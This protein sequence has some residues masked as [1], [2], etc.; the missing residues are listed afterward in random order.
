MV[1]ARTEEG[2]LGVLRGHA[3][4]LS[5]LID[6]A[7]EIEPLD[8][9]DRSSPSTAGF[10]S[11]AND[12][13]SIL[14]QHAALAEEIK[15]DEAR[16]SCEAADGSCTPETSGTRGSVAPRLGSGRPR[17]PPDPPSCVRRACR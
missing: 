1:I 11:V 10:L 14:S 13:V 2:D 6:A 15:I 7:V 5:A 8:G 3:P 4:L 9:G 16:R 17:R 12:R